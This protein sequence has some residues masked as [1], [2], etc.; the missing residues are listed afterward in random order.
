MTK[1]GSVSLQRANKFL[2]DIFQGEETCLEE[3]SHEQNNEEQSILKTDTSDLEAPES[4]ALENIF[5]EI[6]QLTE[7]AAINHFIEVL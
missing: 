5:T 1:I 3:L 6:Q 2:P 4:S 7:K